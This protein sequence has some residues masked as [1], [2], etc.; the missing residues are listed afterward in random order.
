MEHHVSPAPDPAAAAGL[1]GRGPRRQHTAAGAAIGL[2][3]S[4]TSAALKELERM[5]GAPL[6]DRVGKRLLLN[7]SGRALLPRALALLDGA[8]SLQRAAQG[9]QDS[10]TPCASAPAPPSATT[11]CRAGSACTGRPGTPR[12]RP[13]GTRR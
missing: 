11:C 5:L 3:Q 4:A 1:H 9:D 7:S 6:F 13:N 10:R 12:S 8:A 2:S